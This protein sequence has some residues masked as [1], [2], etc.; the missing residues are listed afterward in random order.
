MGSLLENI[1]GPEDV[2]A[3]PEDKL[4]VLAQEIRDEMVRVL[5][6]I[7]GHFGGGMGVVELTLA[8]HRIFDTS[9]DRIVWDVGHQAYPHKMLTGRLSSLPTIRQWNGLCGFPKREESIHDAF[10]AGH[11]GTSVSAALGM[12]EARD[13]LGDS[14]HVIA[15]VG[16]GSLTA[17]MAMEALN[18]AGARKKNLLVILNDNNLS[19][20]E[21]VGALSSYLA[22]LSADPAI[23]QMRR[24]TGSLLR[25]IPVIGDSVAR[26]A[27]AA[28]GQ[29]VGMISPPGLWFEEMGL[30]YIGPIDGHDLPLL[31]DTIGALK[32]REGAVLLHVRT[33]KGKG[34]PP[35]EKSPI[36]FHGVPPFDPET[37]AF[38]KKAGGNPAYTK[39]FGQAMIEMAREIPE[40]FAITAAMPEGTGLTDF[41]KLYPE[42]FV[43]VGIAEQHA[44]T[45]AGGMAAQGARP[46]VAIYS[47]F[48]QRAYDQIVHDICL[49]NLPVVFAMDRGGLVGEDG[50]THH[51]VFDIAYLRHIPNMTVMAP[52]D[53]NELRKMLWTALHHPG[54]VAVRYPRGEALGVPLDSGFELLPIGKAELLSEGRDIV[55]LAYGSMVPVAQKAAEILRREGVDAGLVNMRFAKPLDKALLLQ[56]AHTTSL[57]VTVEEG[58]V[59]GG[60]GSAV[61]EFLSTEDLAGRVRVRLAGI[62]DHYVEHGA[63]G[64]LRDSVGLTPEHLV[65]LVRK[66]LQSPVC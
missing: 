50:P 8:L 63:P 45:L 11:A 39:I 52:K 19:I 7:G 3:L 17:G 6:G 44:V 10:S 61:L 40:L 42:R 29:V 64:I 32:D 27:K 20:S 26:F 56:L 57:F 65:E 15:V 60:L 51:G 31:I 34:Y 53:E 24:K 16:D 30:S 41:G 12:A 58:T 23:D 1:K 54:P 21:N 9:R 43:D 18:Q 5:S 28:H 14:Y 66:N 22:R 4:P 36:A 35:A 25:D 55:F 2:K 13:L 38:K 48:L 47:T 59:L 37:G 49:Q 46:V 62:P 33:I